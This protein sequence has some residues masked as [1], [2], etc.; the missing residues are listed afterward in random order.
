MSYCI[1]HDLHIWISHM[2]CYWGKGWCTVG[3]LGFPSLT[4]QGALRAPLG[5]GRLNKTCFVAESDCFH[6][7]IDLIEPGD[8]IYWWN[9]EW[10]SCCK[11]KTRH[12]T[13][14]RL[15]GESLIWFKTK[16]WWSGA[17]CES[18]EP[19]W[20]QTSVWLQVP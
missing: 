1:K 20:L 13:A 8:V 12:W 14:L 11:M 9:S 2:L 7:N 15:D 10:G 19:Q 17:S 3:V 5:S 16:M 4:A 6:C 18:R